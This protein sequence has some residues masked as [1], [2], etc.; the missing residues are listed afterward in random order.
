MKTHISVI[1]M[2][3][4]YLSSINETVEKS[5][6]EYEAWSF[7]ADEKS[8]NDLSK[9]V[10]EGK[11]TSTTSLHCLYAFEDE[12]LPEEN[13]YSIILDGNNEAQCVI[14]TTKVSITPFNEVT[15]TFAKTEGEGDMSLEYWKKVH[16][17]FF[18]KDLKKFEKAFTEN[19]LVV[20]ETFEVVYP[21]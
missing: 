17:A 11:K 7:G 4:N 12:E 10:L 20:C 1:N 6:K 13:A 2:W 8:A 16:R 19:M 5:E 9:L 15:E 14:K 18:S 3:K 21:R